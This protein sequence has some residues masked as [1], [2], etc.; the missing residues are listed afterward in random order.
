MR[1]LYLPIVFVIGLL[2]VLGCA[3]SRKMSGPCP[4]WFNSPPT[5]PEHIYA[6]ATATSSQLQLALNKAKAESRTEL[7]AQIET[8]VLALIKQF[9]AETG[10]PADANVNT[11]YEQALKQ[12]VS[13]TLTGSRVAKQTSAKE[14]EVWRAC[15]LM[16]VPTGEANAALLNQA[17]RAEELYTRFRASQSFQEMEQE[18][19]KYEQYKKEQQGL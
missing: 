16:E 8:R 4:D 11:L 19:E 15:M 2:L 7:A 18:V 14:G 13:Q 9:D 10:N 12:V 6:V 17:K 3:G 1:R 5:D